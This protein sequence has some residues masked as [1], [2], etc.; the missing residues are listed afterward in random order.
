[1]MLTLNPWDS[2]NRP[3]EAEAMPLPRLETT[4]PV[5]KIYFAGFF[6]TFLGINYLLPSLGHQL[7]D[8]IQ[9]LAGVNS[10]HLDL[11]DNR[12]NLAAVLKRP[13]LLQTLLDFKR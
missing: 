2:N 8:A 7:S 5:T 11:G 13:Q 4:P 9:I 12:A 1:M 6:L 3:I 10:D